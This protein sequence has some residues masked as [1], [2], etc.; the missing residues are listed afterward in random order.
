MRFA[1]KPTYPRWLTN[2]RKSLHVDQE[3]FAAIREA[4]ESD[5]KLLN[6][7]PLEVVNELQ[8]SMYRVPGM[9]LS[10]MDVVVD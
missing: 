7:L 8:R 3:A 2:D 4:G 5:D 1:L 9:P 6:L 10:G